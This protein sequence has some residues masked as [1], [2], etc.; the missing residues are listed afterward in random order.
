VSAPH[1]PVL[2]RCGYVLCFS[3]AKAIELR[4]SETE[5][6]KPFLVSFSGMDGAGKSTQIEALRVFLESHGL[7][8]RLLAFWDD[9]VVLS[10]YREGFV[11]KV[12]KSERGIGEPGK[13]VNRR[14][15]NVRG[16]YVN[17]ARHGLYLL[18]ALNL[19]LVISRA[20]RGKT[21]HAN[22]TRLE[23]RA[24]SLVPDVIIM[25]RYIHDEL[26]NLPLGNALTRA[27]VKLVAA[28]APRPD[29]AY[30]LDADPE[31]ARARKPEYPLDFL[32]S[33]RD[34]YHRLAGMLG[35]TVIPPSSI[36]EATSGIQQALARG[37]QKRHGTDL[38]LVPDSI[39][40]PQLPIAS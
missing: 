1:L 13:P 12:F 34:S 26:A 27:F 40:D 11:H 5:T 33:C 17:F 2:G 20:G 35:M 15:K 10:R 19:R 39:S 16:W 38:P 14:D 24:L 18:D 36:A 7:R 21:S 25:D 30:V 3:P 22:A 6:M 31:A 29:V 8:T 4:V 23:L 9:V 32:I 37:W 28:L